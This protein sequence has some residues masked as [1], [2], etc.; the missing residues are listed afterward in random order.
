MRDLRCWLGLHIVNPKT[1]FSAYGA[2]FRG[3]S[4]Q[5]CS[6][7]EQGK[8]LYNSWGT[9]QDKGYAVFL[10]GT[11]PQFEADLLSGKYELIS[12]YDND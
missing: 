9:E 3:G 12:M 2:I 11:N 10:T 7:W 5:R 6:K 1:I 8:F 4:C